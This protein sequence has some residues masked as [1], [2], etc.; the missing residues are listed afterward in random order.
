MAR[1]RQRRGW[2]GDDDG[3]K[4]DQDEEEVPHSQPHAHPNPNHEAKQQ[5]QPGGTNHN[6]GDDAATSDDDDEYDYLLDDDGGGGGGNAIRELE[7]R[8]RAEMEYEMLVRQVAAQHGYGV[9][10]Q[11]HP[12][13]VLRVAG[14][15]HT[16]TTAA[17]GVG[18]SSIIPPPPAVVLHLF[19]P[20]STA[21]ASLD[22]YLE[23]NV[24]PTHLGT[25]FLRSIGRSTLKVDPSFAQRHLPSNLLLVDD[26][27]DRRDGDVL[28]A[29]VAI[30][31]GVVVNSC[32]GLHGLLATSSEDDDDD[33]DAVVVVERHAVRMWLE[34]S[35]VLLGRPPA[36]DY[37]CA[38][39]PEE[40]ALM[41]DHSV[42]SKTNNNEPRLPLEER[43]NCGIDGCNK[44]FRHEHVGIQTPEQDGLVVKK[45][46]IVG[47]NQSH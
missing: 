1:A 27:P 8:R 6:G 31:D 34:N 37:L 44:T 32:P 15:G 11:V 12:T 19:D 43:Y 25:I 13:R 24:A 39:R 7:E 18:R 45:E 41:M 4:E 28:P 10:R 47:D 35:G 40:D 29:L 30:R 33:A 26:Y 9:H 3:N 17:G 5:Q 20:D 2:E 21:S 14:L 23:T 22:H 42:S 16:N 38:I 46:A 36:L